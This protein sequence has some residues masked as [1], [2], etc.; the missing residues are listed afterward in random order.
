MKSKKKKKKKKA[1]QN[2]A[3]SKSSCDYQKSEFDKGKIKG[4]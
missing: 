1:K 2:Q 3:H 4:R